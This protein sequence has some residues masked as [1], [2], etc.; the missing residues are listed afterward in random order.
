MAELP[1]SGVLT[2]LASLC[3]QL[4]D[5]AQGLASV[6]AAL[7]GKPVQASPARSLPHSLSVA[8]LISSY[9]VA[10]ARLGMS[11][12]YLVQL[13]THLGFFRRWV[14]D[15]D[16][17]SVSVVDVEKFVLS[18][19]SDTS[20]A[21]ALRYVSVLYHW[22]TRRGLV[23]S[24]PAA[25]VEMPRKAPAAVAIHSP[26][27]VRA[28]LDAARARS[29]Q[30]ARFLAVR[31]FA[32]L[33]GSE[34]RRLTQEHIASDRGFLEVPAAI[35]KTRS[36]RLVPI[37]DN[38]KAWLAIAEGFPSEDACVRMGPRYAQAAG[39]RWSQNVTRHSW[40]SYRLALTGSAGTTSLEAGHTEDVLFRNY[41][42]LVTVDQA[43]EY[44]GILPS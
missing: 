38:L 23:R 6:A 10:K 31:Y 21:N 24:N 42:E 44:F 7:E 8:E 15:V 41:R 4:A 1:S 25:G 14:G 2:A 12:G 29:P 17:D 16:A 9:L 13:R 34:A 22:G 20:R 26:A 39:V 11:K 28:V 5:V 33:R 35:A 27:E 43:R 32:G 18:R 30:D 37:S 3:R 19:G 40:V 36:R